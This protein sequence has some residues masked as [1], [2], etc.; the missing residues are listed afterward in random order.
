[1]HK[2]AALRRVF[3]ASSR[4]AGKLEAAEPLPPHPVSKTPQPEVSKDHLQVLCG[5]EKFRRRSPSS[6]FQLTV[7]P[8]PVPLAEPVKAI[9][10]LETETRGVASTRLRQNEPSADFCSPPAHE[11]KLN[12][13]RPKAQTPCTHI[14]QGIYQELKEAFKT[15]P[16]VRTFNLV[17]TVGTGSFGRVYMAKIKDRHDAPPV[18]IKRLTKAA[19][20]KQK[21]VEH[22]LSE[23][24]ILTRVQHPF[25]VRLHATFQDHAYLYIVMEYVEGGEFFT[26]LRKS[27]RLDAN[28]ARFYAAHITSIF[29]YLHPMNVIYRDLKPENLLITRNG[30]LKLTDFGFAKVVDHRTFTLCGTPEYIAP[31][32]LLNKGHGK[33]VDWWTLGILVYEM[34]VGYPPFFDEDALGIYQKILA[35][36]IVF[37]RFFQ[38]DAKSLVKRLLTHDLTRRFGHVRDGISDVRCHRW[39]ESFDFNGLETQTLEPPYIPTVN[40]SIVTTKQR[41][42]YRPWMIHRISETTMKMR[43]ILN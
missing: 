34:I 27:K 17:K 16:S 33:A 1:M 19:V 28:S 13:F 39:F 42:L 24:S 26:F 22:V 21:Q 5:G 35:G 25:L 30:Y 15:K 10:A 8:I 4:T 23:K 20:I 41:F 14:D 9:S 12:E 7:P 31:E 43:R 3:H 38:R 40:V 11:G 18:A 36:K 37:P 32:V 6:I 29:E 2:F